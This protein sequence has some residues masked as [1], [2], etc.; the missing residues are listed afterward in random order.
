MILSFFLCIILW[1]SNT[2]GAPIIELD[3]AKIIE[4]SAE[5]CYYEERKWSRD[6][7][8]I[9][10]QL[11]HELLIEVPAAD[12]MDPV[13]V[14]ARSLWTDYILVGKKDYNLLLE[15]YRSF[16]ASEYSH[17]IAPIKQM[18]QQQGNPLSKARIS[19][20]E[21][22]WHHI[23]QKTDKSLVSH[24]FY[25]HRTDAYPACRG[26]SWDRSIPFPNE[27][28]NKEL[29]HFWNQDEQLVE[30]RR[31]RYIEARQFEEERVMNCRFNLTWRKNVTGDIRAEWNPQWLEGA[32]NLCYLMAYPP[33][34]NHFLFYSNHRYRDLVYRLRAIYQK[35]VDEALVNDCY[36]NHRFEKAEHC[37]GVTW[38]SDPNLVPWSWY[39]PDRYRYIYLKL[40]EKEEARR[41]RQLDDEYYPTG[42]IIDL[43]L[44][45]HQDQ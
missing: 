29:K 23:T 31:K 16:N 24:C 35:Q 12:E 42:K 3:E 39:M 44:N 7:G 41:L 8:S 26:I 6:D 17:C 21:R 45:C 32:T 4:E 28:R 37:K 20:L 14:R 38:S 9:C 22:M 15:C 11:V 27:K 33:P 10:H 18:A 36:L 5:F 1:A 34:L 13:L 30:Y 43:S 19:M 40:Q 25:H 2:N